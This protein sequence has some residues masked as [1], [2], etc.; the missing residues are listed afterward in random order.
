MKVKPVLILLSLFGLFHSCQE[1]ELEF[2]CDPVIDS[3][4][5]E[6]QEELSQITVVEFNYIY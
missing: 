5:L 2:S 1:T 3:F 6:N 4:V